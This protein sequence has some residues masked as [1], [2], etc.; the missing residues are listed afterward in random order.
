MRLHFAPALVALVLS[1]CDYA[2]QAPVT[3][4][5]EADTTTTTDSAANDSA[6]NDTREAA[7]EDSLD[8]PPRTEDAHSPALDTEVGEVTEEDAAQTVFE[9][10]IDPGVEVTLVPEPPYVPPPVDPTRPYRRMDIDQLNASIRRATGGV[11]WT[12]MN[13]TVEEDLFRT[14][15]GTLGKP[16]FINTTQEDLAPSA[17]FQKFLGEAARSV[18][19]T[20]ATEEAAQRRPPLLMAKVTA[21]DTWESA[22][23]KVD[24]NLVSLLRRFHS[25]DLLPTSP[26]FDR[27]RWLF[28]SALHT[29]ND[30]VIAWRTVCI[31]LI[32]HPDFWTY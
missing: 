24:A 23:D 30:P 5:V 19:R 10:L 16:D 17:L 26:G 27:W 31:G 2:K 18:C 15:S 11:G 25:S 7:S 4:L 22:P 20:L 8:T 3:G 32:T 14:L 21:T 12:R 28:R 29:S 13:G 6:A 1:A 9:V